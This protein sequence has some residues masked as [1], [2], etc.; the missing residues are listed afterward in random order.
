MRLVVMTFL[1]IAAIS[2]CARDMTDLDQYVAE[3]HAREGGRIEP[4]PQIKPYETFV[5]SASDSRS[6]FLPAVQEREESNFNNGIRPDDTRPREFLE[7]FPLDTLAMVGTLNLGGGEYALIKTKDGLLHRVKEGN[8][9]GQSEG[10]VVEISQAE[11][12]LIEIISDG[13]G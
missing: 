10:R 7:Q 1:T 2:G 9:M 5:Y 6:P 3:V 4:L 11:V 12:K 13:L 8:H